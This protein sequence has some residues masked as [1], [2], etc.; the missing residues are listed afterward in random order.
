[1][2]INSPDH[3]LVNVTLEGVDME[4]LKQQTEHFITHLRETEGI[5]PTHRH[6]LHGIK[7]LLL[8]IVGLEAEDFKPPTLNTLKKDRSLI[9]KARDLHMLGKSNEGIAEQ[10]NLEPKALWRM[11]RGDTFLDHL[12]YPTEFAMP[13]VYDYVGSGEWPWTETWDGSIGESK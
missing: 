8:H 10:L 11:L 5:A 9:N 12:Y 6:S 4:L 7:N 2:A 3:R 1:M 13:N